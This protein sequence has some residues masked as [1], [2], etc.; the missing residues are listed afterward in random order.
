MKSWLRG[1][2]PLLY[3][4]WVLECEDGVSTRPIDYLCLRHRLPRL[5]LRRGVCCRACA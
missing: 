5:C 2:R 3:L 4:G 1:W